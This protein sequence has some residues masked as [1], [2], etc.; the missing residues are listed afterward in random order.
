MLHFGQGKWYPNEALPRWA[1]HCISRVD[2]VPV[3]EDGALI[4]SEEAQYGFGV[5]E[6][7]A[8][9]TGADASAAGER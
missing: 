5:A 9:L 7:L 3:W 8:F 6:A 4:A 1:Y 2:G